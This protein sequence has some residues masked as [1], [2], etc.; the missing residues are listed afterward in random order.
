VQALGA[1]FGLKPQL[2]PPPPVHPNVCYISII[3]LLRV[4]DAKQGEARRVAGGEWRVAGGGRRAAGGRRQ[5]ACSFEGG[6]EQKE[7]AGSGVG[8]R[9]QRSKE[10]TGTC[11]WLALCSDTRDVA[12]VDIEGVPP[13]NAGMPAAACAAAPTGVARAAA[14]AALLLR[15]SASMRSFSS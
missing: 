6:G 7:E 2:P 10:E 1:L 14:R 3:T 12:A 11:S 13:I 5:A 9:R 8:G 4:L 15:R